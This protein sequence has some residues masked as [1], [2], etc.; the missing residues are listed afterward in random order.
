MTTIDTHVG[1]ANATVRQGSSFIAAV[2]R[3]MTSSDH[4][5]IGRL[6]VGWSLLF[7]VACTVIG[8]VAGLERMRPA[9][10]QIV[11][12]DA[13][14]QITGVYRY[15]LIF[16]LLAPLFVGLAIA[17]VPMQVGARAIAM[18][19]LAQAA[20]WCWLF[21]VA[22]VVISIVGNGGPGG[23]N[24]DLVDLYLLGVAMSAV[25]ILS[26]S[27]CIATTVL[28]SRTAGMSLDLVPP[29]SWAALVGSVTT[30]LSLPV[31]I[32]TV[33]YLYVDHTH[34][35]AAF[36]GNR[37]IDSQLRWSLSQP[38]SFVFV[39]MALGV[40][41]EL[42]PLVGRTR[43]PLRS[44]LLTGLGLV[45]TGVLGAVTQSS[46]TLDW[47]GSLSSKI[48]SAVLFILFNGLPLLGVVMVVA[49]SLLSLRGATGVLTPSFMFAGSGALLVL[50]GA[51]GHFFSA[52]D[53]TDLAG[54]AFEEG[55]VVYIVLGGLLCAFG[56][57]AHWAPKLWGRVLPGSGF[58]I[59]VS[60]IAL[61][62]SL[63]AAFPL[64]VAGLSGQPIDSMY[65]FSYD[66]PIALWNGLSAA[67]F[68]LVI[69]A[70]LAFAAVLVSALRSGAQAPDDPWDGQTLEWSLPSP[71]PESNSD[72]LAVVSSSEPLL[73]VKPSSQE[74]QS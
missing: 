10:L 71:A 64:Y 22:L 56:A 1:A 53:A 43:Q 47:S 9:G 46:H 28:T 8:L 4:K 72:T 70:L 65:D 39:V 67:G 6:F 18:P 21:G 26:G 13:V 24:S 68:V 33:V 5:R 37:G 32:G 30:L 61:F 29:F 19:R 50:A 52:I 2:G 27:L 62:G 40:L 12:G 54:T 42:A 44:A 45:T 51:A 60:V 57:L 59:P 7:A 20:F 17:V 14:L 38:Q 16:A 73:D 41:A 74:V 66:G 15:G 31:A 63:A 11:P 55:V 69:L 58:L 36:G 23:G 3:W 49:V 48:Q 25:G 34:V 35:R